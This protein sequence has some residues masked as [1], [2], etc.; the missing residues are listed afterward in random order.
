M[1]EA[2]ERIAR[3]DPNLAARLIVMTMPAVVDRVEASYDLIVRDLGSWRVRDGR[4]QPL[5][6]Q[7]EPVDFKLATDAEG[8]AALV[9]GGG[10]RQRVVPRP[11]RIRGGRP[12]AA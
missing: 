5:N 3:E 9:A 2:L 7:T 4:M 12:P 11:G 10:G 1:N 6:G 8:L